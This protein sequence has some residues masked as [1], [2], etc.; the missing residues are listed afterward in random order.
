MARPV[1][2]PAPFSRAAP[3]AARAVAALGAIVAVCTWAPARP[4]A[5]GAEVGDRVAVVVAGDGEPRTLEGSVV[6]EALDGG[7]LLHLDDQRL[8]LVQPDTVLE[9]RTLPAPDGDDAPT[10]REVGKRILAE[11]PDGFDML[12]TRHYVVCFDTSR[13]YAQWC[14]S[15][16]ERLHATF[17]NYWKKSGLEVEAPREALVVVIFAERKRYEAFAA[18]D[19]GAASDRVVGY[20]NM[21]DNRITTFDLT[22][23]DQ[24]ARH[25]AATASRAG[26]EILSSPEAA[27]LV[28]T[29]VHEASHQMAFNCGL[30]RR[31]APVPVWLSEGVATFFETPDPGGRGWKGIGGVNRPRLEKFLAGYRPGV[32]EQIVLGDE[33][34]R[35]PDESVDAYARAWALTAF[36]AQSRRAALA[37]YMATMAASGSLAADDPETRRRDF[38]DAFGI[39][40]AELEEPLLKFLARRK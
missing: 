31:L 7:M 36:L 9:R 5:R 29:L 19:L 40:P 28:S 11:L 22:G 2:S 33:A 6:V 39:E 37:K 35:D 10:A 34:F 30:H 24:L 21:L 17:L 12:V 14:A 1:R 25:P 3:P 20:Y 18:R 32:L 13:A 26:L 4:G 15:L 38:V 23:S 27:S 8:E 16:F